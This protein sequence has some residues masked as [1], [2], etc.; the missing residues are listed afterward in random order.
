M[1]KIRH[2]GHST[3]FGEW[4]RNTI[5]ELTSENGYLN[6][7]I[8]YVWRNKPLKK[9]YILEEKRYYNSR[10]TISTNKYGGVLRHFNPSSSQIETLQLIDRFL[11]NSKDDTYT[12]EGCYVIYF[13]NTCPADGKIYLNSIE[14][15]SVISQKL[16]DFTFN[17]DFGLTLISTEGFLKFLKFDSSWSE[18]RGKSD[19]QLRNKKFVLEFLNKK[20]SLLSKEIDKIEKQIDSYNNYF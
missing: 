18:E 9:F 20:R 7:N 17:N 6:H 2:D 10:I 14:E 1:T 8:D 5:P 11:R 19:E 13:E 4:I 15:I 12:Y 3:E 16:Y